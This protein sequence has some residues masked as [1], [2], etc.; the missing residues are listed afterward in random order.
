MANTGYL[1]LKWAREHMD[2]TSNIRQ[3][4]I[5]EKPFK[6]IRI[7]MAL[8]VEAKTG[9][10]AI[11]LKE[12]GADIKMASCNPLS[13]DDYVVES[14]KNDYNIPVFAR[15]GET[16]EEY[17]DYL[18]KIVDP[19]PDIIIDDGGDLTNLVSS[20]EKL[21]KNI[22]GGNEETTTGVVRLKAME[23][24]NALKFPMFDV[25]DAKMKH[26]FDNRYG[27]GQSAL[28]GFMNAT[29]ILI[30]GKRIC[31]IGYGWV[32]RGI[33]MRLKGLGAIVTISEVDP[34]KAVEALMDGFSVDTVENAVKYS[35]IVFTATGMKNVVPYSALLKAKNGIILGNAGHFN[36]EIDM[37]SIESKNISK[38]RVRD[39]I[40]EYRLENGNRINIISDGRLLNLAAGQGHPIEIMDLSF[41]IQALT[42]EYIVKNHDR[43]E[44]RVYPVP[45]D[46]DKN[47]A[48]IKLN[49]LGIKID[50]L[51][52][53][54]IMYMN[55]FK[56]GT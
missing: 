44:K 56:E 47:V 26:L 51:T 31:V 43:L 1:R 55:S 2:I 33:A 4:F 39:Y 3:R 17:Y 54:Q 6:G 40:T 29:N 50:K 12:G 48:E 15:K 42:A 25:N 38:E 16:Q 19:E 23:K 52:D 45:E 46:I 7:A 9:V 37:E 20:D 34:V 53:E 11:L 35:D 21:Y 24:S 10:F 30:A 18:N 49:A 41:S 28:D 32:G 13:S 22:M 5:E 14:L 8:H 27:T 36:N